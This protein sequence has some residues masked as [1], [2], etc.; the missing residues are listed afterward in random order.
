MIRQKV[1][2]CCFFLGGSAS[3]PGDSCVDLSTKLEFFLSIGLFSKC[4]QGRFLWIILGLFGACS[5]MRLEK[6]NDFAAILFGF[7]HNAKKSFAFLTF[8]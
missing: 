1:H 6:K 5:E 3:V 7:Q 4:F 2:C 8:D